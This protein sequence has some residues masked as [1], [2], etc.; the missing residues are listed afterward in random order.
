MPV[1]VHTCIHVGQECAGK[2]NK[3]CHYKEGT[4]KGEKGEND[5][6]KLGRVGIKDIYM[7]YRVLCNELMILF[8]ID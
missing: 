3:I 4:E 5:E 7:A 1:N 2:T 6:R 8:I